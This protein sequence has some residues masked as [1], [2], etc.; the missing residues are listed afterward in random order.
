M[1]VLADKCWL[2]T[3]VYLYDLS[4]LSYQSSNLQGYDLAVS[5]LVARIGELHLPFRLSGLQLPLQ[6]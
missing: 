3:Y 2:F 4:N 5:V 1:E 6:I